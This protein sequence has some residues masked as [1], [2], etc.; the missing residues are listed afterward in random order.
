MPFNQIE[1][2]NASGD[3][4]PVIGNTT[5]VNLALGSGAYSGKY[6][7][8]V[9]EGCW[10]ADGEGATVGEFVLRGPA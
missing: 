7:R 4:V 8:L 3:V 5:R 6:A 1:A 9:I 2:E 10:E